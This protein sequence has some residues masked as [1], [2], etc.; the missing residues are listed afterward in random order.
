MAAS[1][2]V[3]LACFHLRLVRPLCRFSRLSHSV[4][5]VCPSTCPESG[6]EPLVNC[7]ETP[8]CPAWS[9]PRDRVRTGWRGAA[10]P[11]PASAGRLARPSQPGL[12]R[13]VPIAGRGAC[14]CT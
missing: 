3:C 7:R 4:A 12:E 1:L 9:A 14:R 8:E 2:F 11:S 10:A 13:I 5:V 6:P